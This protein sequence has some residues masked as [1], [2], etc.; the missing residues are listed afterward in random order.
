VSK[1]DY[2]AL[3]KLPVEQRQQQALN[4]IKLSDEQIKE[5]EPIIYSELAKLDVIKRLDTSYE[6]FRNYSDGVLSWLAHIIT[7]ITK[8][9]EIRTRIF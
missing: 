1:D 9:Y 4:I 5:T 7:T 6:E 3:Q 8:K 2:D